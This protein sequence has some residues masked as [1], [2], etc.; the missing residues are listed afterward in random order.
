MSRINDALKSAEQ[1]RPNDEAPA[2]APALLP[3]GGS[4]APGRGNAPLITLI[5][6]TMLASGFMAWEWF[7]ADA[8]IVRARTNDPAVNSVSTPA[9]TPETNAAPA[10]VVAIPE[11]NFLAATTPNTVV[12]EKPVA[13]QVV[14]HAIATV[15][16]PKPPPVTYKLQ[17]IIYE[18]GRCSAVINGK[19][20]CKGE[21]VEDSRVLS[22]GKDTVVLVN[23][24][25]QTNVLE[26]L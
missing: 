3:P 9:P 14:S 4:P 12:N 7:R 25:G 5:A 18:P 2:A 10:L 22:I 1:A 26:L 20:V 13:A 23:A 6:V 15:E 24:A 11:T 21:R 8:V 19:T 17:G 16:P